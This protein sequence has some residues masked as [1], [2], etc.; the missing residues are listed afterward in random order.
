MTCSK[1][2]VTKIKHS[3]SLQSQ[4]TDGKIKA[5]FNFA[6]NICKYVSKN[7]VKSSIHPPF[8]TTNHSSD[9]K[10]Q[11]LGICHSLL[12]LFWPYISSYFNSDSMCDPYAYAV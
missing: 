8:I 4:R 11:F 3:K 2:L 7:E 5:S 9:K 10:L 1:L 12:L 6:V